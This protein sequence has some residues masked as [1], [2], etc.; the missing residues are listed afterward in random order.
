MVTTDTAAPKA[1]A[2]IAPPPATDRTE[3]FSLA[4]ADASFAVITLPAPKKALTPESG[5][6]VAVKAAP[7]LLE[8]RLVVAAPWL[9]V[10]VEE[11]RPELPVVWL[12]GSVRVSLPSAPRL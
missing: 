6:L 10:V 12:P 4:T 1:A 9:A 7:E 8:P 3:I 2:P 5:S 11:I